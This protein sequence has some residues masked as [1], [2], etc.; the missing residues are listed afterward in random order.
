[1][2]TILLS[3]AL[4]LSSVFCSSAQTKFDVNRLEL[5]GHLGASFGDYTSINIS[6]RIGYAI[7]SKFSTGIGTSYSYYDYKS[8][9][10]NYGGMNLYVHL[11]P[12]QNFILLAEPEILRA[13]GS[14]IE[15]QVV[16]CLLLGGGI[17]LPVGNKS[18]ISMTFAYDVL[19]NKE[20]PYRGELVY[21]VGYVFRF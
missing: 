5:G 11:K 15:S 10:R 4:L 6:P 9:S 14:N 1:M 17:I 19:Q 18:G 20:S 16:P 2:K 7:S 8:F 21:S 3:L 13:W 12:I